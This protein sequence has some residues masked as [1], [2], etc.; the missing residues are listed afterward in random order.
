[1]ITTQTTSTTIAYYCDCYCNYDCNYRAAPDR[2]EI[3][4][5][6]NVSD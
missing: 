6:G 4:L 2:A 3:Q 1:M 5:S